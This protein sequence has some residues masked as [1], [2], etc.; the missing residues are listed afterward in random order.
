MLK[1][2][3]KESLLDTYPSERLPVIADVL[4][5]TTDL[6]KRTFSGEFAKLVLG[7]EEKA[8]ASGEPA[9]KP[10]AAPAP[11]P[12]GPGGPGGP[13]GPGRRS[14]PVRD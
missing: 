11:G 13:P 1:G 9:G 10:A 4:N 14:S 2:L 5:F 6:Y 12:G 7:N 3:A 8:G